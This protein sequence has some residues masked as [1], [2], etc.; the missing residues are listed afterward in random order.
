MVDLK[1]SEYRKYLLDH[2]VDI[3]EEDA[4]AF[5]VEAM[6]AN[7]KLAR[8][9]GIRKRDN[10]LYENYPLFAMVAEVAGDNFMINPEY[11]SSEGEH[12]TGSWI[13]PEFVKYSSPAIFFP[14]NDEDFV[15]IATRSNFP[16]CQK[17]VRKAFILP[18]N[19]LQK[20]L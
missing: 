17:A 9:R 15:K 1:E 8:Q 11:T 3:P 19:N 14:G 5:A 7:Q 18:K 13:S 6:R 2:G 12:F 16:H 4:K 20:Q 10:W